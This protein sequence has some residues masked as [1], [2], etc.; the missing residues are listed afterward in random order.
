M[1]IVS[2]DDTNWQRISRRKPRKSRGDREG[3]GGINVNYI[4]NQKI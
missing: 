3:D 1:R 2:E 4:I